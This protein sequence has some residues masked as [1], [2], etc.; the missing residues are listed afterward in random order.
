MDAFSK[1]LVS[2]E[3]NKLDGSLLCCR[4]AVNII[5]FLA[6]IILPVCYESL[7]LCQVCCKTISYSLG[8]LLGVVV[9]IGDMQIN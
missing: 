4:R 1:L 7:A 3:D 9:V 5:C 8:F 2:S 6:P